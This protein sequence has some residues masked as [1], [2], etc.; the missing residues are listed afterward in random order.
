MNCELAP[1][2]S[3]G[4]M[5]S[6]SVSEKVKIEPATMPGSASGRTTLRSVRQRAGAEV[7][8]G[9]QQRV[10]DPLERAV[11]RHDHERQPDVGEDDPH[12]GVRVADVDRAEAE[13]AGRSS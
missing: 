7:A 6:P 11:D 9:L 13:L 4:V 5:K 2:T 1:P 10:G 3:S 8:G 12:R